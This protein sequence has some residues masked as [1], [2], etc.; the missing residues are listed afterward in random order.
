LAIDLELAE[1]FGEK[2]KH[3]SSDEIEIDMDDNLAWKDH[4]IHFRS[5]EYDD[6]LSLIP[7]ADAIAS[8]RKHLSACARTFDEPYAMLLH[9]IVWLRMQVEQPALYA[10]MLELERNRPVLRGDDEADL[11]KMEVAQAQQNAA[12][13]A[14]LIRQWFHD[15]YRALLS[16]TA[17]QLLLS[18]K[19]HPEL[20]GDEDFQSDLWEGFANWHDAAATLSGGADSYLSRE[21]VAGYLK[22]TGF[23]Q[24]YINRFFKDHKSNLPGDL[25]TYR[26]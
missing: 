5:C 18:Y 16:E 13:E 15:Q 6:Q 21:E 23:S 17:Q 20:H 14:N 22:Q 2:K 3:S 9:E 26:R 4:L 12:P 19:V 25:P 11:Q 7:D 1:R 10:R 8:L 24:N